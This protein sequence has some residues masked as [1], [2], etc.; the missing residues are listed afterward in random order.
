MW[1]DKPDGYPK[2][3]GYGY[4]FLH[5]GMGT[6]FY[7][8]PLYWRT[9]NCSTRLEPDPL[10]SLNRSLSSHC[11]HFET[12]SWALNLSPPN[13]IQIQ[14]SYERFEPHS[15]VTHS[16]FN[17]ST[18][19]TISVCSLLLKICSPIQTRLSRSHQG[20]GWSQK[21]CIALSLVGIW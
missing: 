20:Y 7:P 16:I 12:L 3:G 8:R 21:V 15:W 1:N 14:A 6:N 4:E 13:F 11:K 18:S 17:S 9:S 19:P 10:P 5:A 2:L